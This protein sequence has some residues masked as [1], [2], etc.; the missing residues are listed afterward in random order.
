M[1][2][3]FNKCFCIMKVALP[4]MSLKRL[5]EKTGISEIKIIVVRFF[6]TEKNQVNVGYFYKWEFYLLTEEK[7]EPANW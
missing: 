7:L 3:H 5:L 2:L 1:K 4:E 6:T